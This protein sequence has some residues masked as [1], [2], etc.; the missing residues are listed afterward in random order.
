MPQARKCEAQLVAQVLKCVAVDIAECY[1]LEPPPDALVRIQV[2]CVSRKRQQFEPFGP[3]ISQELLD[4]MAA[5]DRCT[6]PYHQHL[7]RHMA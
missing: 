5:M 6:I 7:A 2:G 4:F 3:T 1:A